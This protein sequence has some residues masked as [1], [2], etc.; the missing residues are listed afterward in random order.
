[1]FKTPVIVP[2]VKGNFVSNCNLL[3]VSFDA[4]PFTTFEILILLVLMLIE[5]E[6]MHGCIICLSHHN[7]V[8]RLVCPSK[9]SVASLL[10]AISHIL[11]FR[12]GEVIVRVQR[13]ID[14]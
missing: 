9:H 10:R 13:A 11:Y 14:C 6:N 5:W 8:G 7:T 2:H 3:T 12:S 1:M 4:V